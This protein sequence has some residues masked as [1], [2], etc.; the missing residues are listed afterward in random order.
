MQ[1]VGTTQG[2]FT[3]QP[4]YNPSVVKIKSPAHKVGLF[5]AKIA[6]WQE[7]KKTKND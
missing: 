2:I 6:I 3:A 5:Y 1:P 4:V 7:I